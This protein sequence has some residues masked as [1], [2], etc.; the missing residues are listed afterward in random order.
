MTKDEVRDSILRSFSRL[1]GEDGPL[2]DYLTEEPSTYDA[3][4]LHEVCINHRL[5]LH[6]E[7]EIIPKLKLNDA[8]F[9][10]LEFNRE[11][12]DPKSA[13]IAGEDK[14]IR[15]DIIIHNRKTG[16]EK[17]NFLIVEC[18]KQNA[19]K[20]E[21]EEDRRKIKALMED[22]NYEYSFGLQV[23]YKRDG[24]MG[25]LFFR[26]NTGIVSETLPAQP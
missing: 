16:R 7:K 11:G 18:K 2:F 14:I 15:P 23:I 17:V 20:Q 4:E 25:K 12:T 3:R 6:F 19:S 8:I 1:I 26:S 5:A 22:K 13:R 24:P 9:V 10:D 21:I